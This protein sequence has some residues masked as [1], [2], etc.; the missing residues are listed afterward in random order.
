VL[1]GLCSC[2]SFS[3]STINRAFTPDTVCW[4]VRIV[5]CENNCDWLTACPVHHTS[6]DN[7]WIL[8]RAVVLAWHV[9]TTVLRPLYGYMGYSTIPAR[10]YSEKFAASSFSEWMFAILVTRFSAALL[11]PLVTISYEKRWAVD[12]HISSFYADFPPHTVH[13]YCTVR[14]RLYH[15]VGSSSF[16]VPWRGNL[17]CDHASPQGAAMAC[18]SAKESQIKPRTGKDTPFNW[19]S[20]ILPRWVTWRGET[21]SGAQ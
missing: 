11:G 6:H 5:F 4:T 18:H 15:T 8:S 19:M 2:H 7:T 9:A 3:D 10:S 17:W 16:L 12:T 1:Y 14:T 21:S 13:R 20:A